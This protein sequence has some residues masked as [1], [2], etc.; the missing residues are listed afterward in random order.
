MVRRV[1]ELTAGHGVLVIDRGG[2]AMSLLSDWLKHD[3]R[4]VARLRGD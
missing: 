4:F 2:D 3:Y 1:F